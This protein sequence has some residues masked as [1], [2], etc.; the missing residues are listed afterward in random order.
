MFIQV[1]IEK[2]LIYIPILIFVDFIYY[3]SQYEL[4]LPSECKLLIRFSAEICLIIF[5]F[6]QNYLSRNESKSKNENL[7][8][9]S[10]NENNII[11][12]F[13]IMIIMILN[14]IFI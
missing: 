9:S 8:V 13:I 14:I 3:Y 4:N 2:N 7:F 12:I 10:Q 11:K 1:S 6:M 5:Y